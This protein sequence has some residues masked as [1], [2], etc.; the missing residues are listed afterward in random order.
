MTDTLAAAASNAAVEAADA[1][2]A[3]QVPTTRLYN[4]TQI[5]QN[6]FQISGSN[7]VAISAG[8]VT[9]EDY[10]TAKNMKQLMKDV[11]YAYLLGVRADGD[12]TTARTMRG[13]LN[14]TTTNLDKAS[15]ATLAASGAVTGGTARPLTLAMIKGVMQDIFDAGGDPTKV[16]CGSFQATQFTSFANTNNYRQMVEA[17][18]LNDYVDVYANEFGKLEVIPHRIMSVSKADVVFI[19][20]MEY[21]KK[22]TYRPIGKQKLSKTGD[23]DKFQILGELTLESRAENA[24][25]RI[26]NLDAS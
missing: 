26:T 18:K 20:D 16:F 13:A 2:T 7:E 11:E 6:T 8:N 24:S 10:L 25:G 17:G 5:L 14:W 22:G 21:F 15:D 3:T 9:K 23:S 1:T 19:A 4:M 12:A